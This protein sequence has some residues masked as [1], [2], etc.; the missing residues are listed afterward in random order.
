MITAFDLEKLHALL[1]DFYEIAHI[2]IT[3]FDENLTE[4]VSYPRDV[5]PYC[6]VIRDTI[7]GYN[8]CVACDRHACSVA[9]KRRETYVYKCHAGFTEAVTPL[10]V[11]DVLVG[12]VLFGHVFSYETPKEGWRVIEKQTEPL[13]VNTRMLKEAVLGAQPI[14]ESYVQSAVQILHAVASYLILERM[15]SLKEDKLAVRL[16]R[17]L[18]EHFTERFTAPHL[19]DIFGIGKT[20]LYNLSKQLYGCGIA[21][22]IRDLRM[23]LARQ[24]LKDHNEHSLAEIASRCGYT[25]YNYFISVFSREH[26]CPPGV[27]RTANVKAV[28]TEG[29]SQN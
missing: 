18:S 4:L 21:E 22:H 20:Q 15:A 10:F 12:Y 11:G 14:T 1:R 5:A 29:P 28:P 16:D 6:R 17:Y 19:C 8:A 3:V 26:G 7:K 24:L 23:S 27:W 2:R 13:Q 25:D 9:T